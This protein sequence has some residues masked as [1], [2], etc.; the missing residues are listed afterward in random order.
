MNYR[1]PIED[2]TWTSQL[3]AVAFDL[4]PPLRLHGYAFASDL[5][6]HY[7]FTE[8]VF[9]SLIGEAPTQ[10]QAKLFEVAL[11]LLSPL[12]VAEAPSHAAVLAKL[13]GSED[14]GVLAAGG[15]V[16]FDR[17]RVLVE[18]H[19]E[20]THW[21]DDPTGALPER[22]LAKTPYEREL[23]GEALRRFGETLPPFATEKLAPNA[24]AFALLLSLGFRKSLALTSVVAI[25]SMASMVSEALPRTAE[26]RDRYPLDV[27]P[28][29]YEEDE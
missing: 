2:G 23:V 22:F 9:T 7:S 4:G 16:L 8:V 10:A 27:P 14:A 26:Q 18:E 19:A 13:C 1:G 15:V 25:A 20:L 5:L 17:A 28:F 6:R 3:E 21:L 29:R 24:L 12:T 11:I